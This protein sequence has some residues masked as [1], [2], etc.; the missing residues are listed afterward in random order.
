M[1]FNKLTVLGTV[2]QNKRTCYQVQC[3]CGK[4]DLK[5]KD[6]VEQGR[7]KMCKP[8]S[9]K[10][11][12]SKYPPPVNRTGCKGLSGTHYTALKAGAKRRNLLFE[13][14]P[15]FLWQLYLQQHKLCAL[16]GSEIIL[17]PAIKDNNVDWNIV[18]ASLD[19]IDSDKGYTKDNVQWVHKRVNFLKNDFTEEELLYWAKKIV[20]KQGNPEPS[21]SGDTL[22][23]ATTRD[24][25]LRVSNVPTSAQPLSPFDIKV[26]QYMKE[27]ADYP[28]EYQKLFKS[29]DIV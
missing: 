26:I 7:T 19:R 17:V 27:Y 2:V 12:A 11:T 9:A 23:G 28:T 13:V 29:D 18:T 5:R 8:C 14:S 24:R 4:V 16:S 20:E 6:W 1:K 22:E 3:D 10:L 25:D 15:E 21:Q